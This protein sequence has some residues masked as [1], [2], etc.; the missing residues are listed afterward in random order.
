MVHKKKH[1]GVSPGKESGGHTGK[2]VHKDMTSI[3]HGQGG[4]DSGA[5]SSHHA[6]NK[7][8]GMEHGFHNDGDESGEQGQAGIPNT[9][10]NCCYE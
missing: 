4:K 8:H 9:E 2:I 7:E 3:L 6:A 5:H 10:G 1:G